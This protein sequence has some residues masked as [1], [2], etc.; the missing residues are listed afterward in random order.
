MPLLRRS[1]SQR[2]CVVTLIAKIHRAYVVPALHSRYR[3]RAD[4]RVGPLPRISWRLHFRCLRVRYGSGPTGPG[5][6]L[7]AADGTQWNHDHR[8]VRYDRGGLP[9]GLHFQ[10]RRRGRTTLQ[11][12]A[13]QCNDD[14]HLQRTID[15]FSDEGQRRIVGRPLFIEQFGIRARGFHGDGWR[16]EDVRSF[17]Q[18]RRDHHGM[19]HGPW[20][21]SRA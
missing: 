7:P 12:A 21:G 15:A 18:E 19:G 17:R 16:R 14:R 13:R 8:D 2:F 5:E 9:Y 6:L 1:T 20:S 11:R 10:R 4:R 3:W